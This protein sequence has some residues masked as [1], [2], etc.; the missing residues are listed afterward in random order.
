MGVDIL[1]KIFGGEWVWMASKDSIHRACLPLTCMNKAIH[2]QLK[3]E[4]RKEKKQGNR[5]DME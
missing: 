4:N 2:S 5:L 1:A 3:K